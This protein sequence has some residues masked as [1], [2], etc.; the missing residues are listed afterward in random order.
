MSRSGIIRKRPK[1]GVLRPYG[2]RPYGLI[3][4]SLGAGLAAILAMQIGCGAWFY[5][6]SPRNSEIIVTYWGKEEH[7]A[8]KP[9]AKK[10]ICS[11]DPKCSLHK[12]IGGK[13]IGEK[14]DR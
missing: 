5:D 8:K 4:R 10:L 9:K 1:R 3:K 2:L 11:C 14:N 7:R 13:K 12:K 6:G